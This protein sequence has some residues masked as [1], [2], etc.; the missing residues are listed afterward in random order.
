[1]QIPFLKQ[2]L[3]G[4]GNEEVNKI[5][6]SLDPCEEVTDLLEQA[7]IDNPPLSIKEGNIIRD[8]YQCSVRPIP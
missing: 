8:G 3:Q 1:M 4:M 7:I 5:A 2:I 6:E